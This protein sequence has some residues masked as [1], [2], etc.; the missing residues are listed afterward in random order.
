MF[1]LF[2]LNHYLQYLILVCILILLGVANAYT[3][4]YEGL[5]C[6]SI[7]VGKSATH[8]SQVFLAHN[9]DDGGRMLVN[10]YKVPP[11][12]H[13]PESVVTLKRGHKLEQV[14]H[15]YGYL[16]L[17]MPGMDFSDSYMNE[18]GVTIASNNCPSRET[19][20]DTTDGG[21][22]F[23]LR[24]LMIERAA[25]AREAVQIGGQL[26]ETIGYGDSGRTY[27]VA[28]TE[29][30]WF[31][32]V[33][34]GRHWIAQRVP[35]DQVAVI[36][37]C[38][39][40]GEVDLSDE[41]NFLGSEDIITY[42]VQRGWYDPTRD[43]S[44]HFAQSYS[45][46]SSWNSKGNRLRWWRALN[47]LAE[48]RYELNDPFPFSFH[49]KSTVS[50]SMIYRVLRDHYEGT[51]YDHTQEYKYG[52]PNEMLISTICAQSNQYGFVAQ[53]RG[54]IPVELG[55][56]LWV[57][58]RRPDIHP[59]IPFYLGMEALPPSLA[60]NTYQYAL[61]YQF[62]PPSDLFE[63]T[64]S[65]AHWK[66]GN[67]AETVDEDYGSEIVSCIKERDTLQQK[68]EQ[69]RISME[70]QLHRNPSEWNID[71]Q[72]QVTLFFNRWFQRIMKWVE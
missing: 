17:Q 63:Q 58:P 44:F 3:Q 35:D 57:A 20:D 65:H 51:I 69:E 46:P 24:R 21:I 7:G 61:S 36:P 60:W 45:N 29:E 34:R 33:V 70:E 11:Q 26:V 62:D 23:W 15:T 2:P 40:I 68:L 32:A 12:D 27:V 8:G 50:R 59:F 38:Y 30:V 14:T 52:S 56:I 49:P 67:H 71:T 16:W 47:L 54:A 64:S 43:G 13:S 72:S 22:R 31:M 4:S 55:A 39:T 25:S 5:N 9:E 18:W 41:R 66:F 42:A 10:Y 48:T 1:D 37:N 53:L 19:G 6:F 28:D